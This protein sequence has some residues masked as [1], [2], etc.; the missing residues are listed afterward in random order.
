MVALLKCPYHKCFK[1]TFSFSRQISLNFR[2]LGEHNDLGFPKGDKLS[3]NITALTLWF[4]CLLFLMFRQI[5]REESEVKQG[6]WKCDGPYLRCRSGGEQQ[7]SSQILPLPARGQIRA[8]FDTCNFICCQWS[9][10]S[11]A[12]FL[13]RVNPLHRT[14]ELRRPTYSGK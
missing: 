14:G 9:Y 13:L 7:F 2:A 12:G 4:S 1:H 8:G 6:K 10:C 3:E 11:K 5:L